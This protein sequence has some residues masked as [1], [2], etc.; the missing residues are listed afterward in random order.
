MGTDR[1][2]SATETTFRWEGSSVARYAG[3]AQRDL[4]GLG[5]RRAVAGTAQEIS[6]VPNLPPPLPAV[7]ERGKLKRILHVLAEELQARG[8]LQLEE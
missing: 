4:V 3:S 8:K 1:T 6:A 5:Y 7:G 2:N